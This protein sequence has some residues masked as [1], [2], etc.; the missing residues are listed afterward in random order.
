MTERI[1]PFAIL[2]EPPAFPPRPA[3]P[4]TVANEAI[5]RMAEDNNF[6]SR[7]A[8]RAERN[9]KRKPRIHRTGRNCQ[10]NVKA[11]RETIDRFYRIADAQGVPL[12]EL[13]A[14]AL[15]AFEH[16]AK[17]TADRA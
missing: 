7:Q 11:T 9:A 3:R 12:G 6:P 15:D 4:K 5:E 2:D 1:N 13:L 10:F 17:Q 14:R 16:Q 8:S